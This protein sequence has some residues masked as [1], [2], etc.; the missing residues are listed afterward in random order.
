M[1]DWC[2]V[3]GTEHG[4]PGDCPGDIQATG[5]EQCGWRISVETPNGV[6]AYGVLV[7]PSN[8]SWRARIVTYPNML[9][10]LPGGRLTMKFVGRT[11][12]EAE[13]RAV[14]LI[15]AHCESR[16]YMPKDRILPA[17][18]PPDTAIAGPGADLTAVHLK[19]AKRK[20]C[21]LP[22]RYGVD[23]PDYVGLTVN[24]S[25]TGLFLGTSLPL[26]S[27]RPIRVDVSL[28]GEQAELRGVVMWNRRRDDSDRPAGMG[29]RLIELPDS[30][31][32]FVHKLP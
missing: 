13:Q 32:A 18:I 20:S 26:K 30:Y 19:P 4:P 24:L 16:G 31:P 17:E 25:R 1:S 21:K 27:G 3:C 12:E 29:I 8:D 22:A 10:T 6:E 11:R 5:P 28:G 23:L 15:S 14:A 2:M 7:A 9:W